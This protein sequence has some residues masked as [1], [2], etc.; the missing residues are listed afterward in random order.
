MVVVP[1]ELTALATE[2]STALLALPAYA[3]MPPRFAQD[4]PAVVTLSDFALRE[5]QQQAVD[6]APRIR[7]SWLWRDISIEDYRSRLA[8][9]LA[10]ATNERQVM[11]QL[12]IFR[13]SE[14]LR[15]VW[16]DL[17][18]AT[19]LAGILHDLS[20]LAD[21]CVQQALEW[22]WPRLCTQMGTP[23][24]VESGTPQ[25]LVVLALGKLG[26][27]ELNL[28][29]DIDLIFAYP[30]E[31]HTQGNDYAFSNH[32]FF[33]RLGQTLIRMLDEA[34][35]DGFVFRVDMRLRPFGEG[36]PL[37]GS[38]ASM[39]AYYQ[40]QG[41]EWE[42]YALIKAR[43]CAGD[44]AAGAQL[45]KAL[46]PFIFRRYIDFG[47]FESLR[48][49]K[50]MIA[51]EVQRKGNHDD[52][53]IGD[54]GIREVEFIAQTFQLIR[55]G[56][57]PALRDSH[58]LSLLPRLAERRLLPDEVVQTLLN[59]YVFLREAEH[60]IQALDERHSQ[61]LPTSDYDRLRLA[62]AMG[63]RNWPAFLSALDAWR[64][65]VAQ[66][67][68]DVITSEAHDDAPWQAFLPV[69]QGNC[70]DPAE[71]QA[72]LTR[73]GFAAP[74]VV[75][76]WLNTL[77]HSRAVAGLPALSRTRLDALM[78]RLLQSA[79]TTA[80]P[81]QTLE[82][83]LPLVEA[84]L[85]RTAYIM[86]LVE[87]RGALQRLVELAAASPWIAEELA[88]YPRLLD[89]LLDAQTL[90]AP[91]EPESLRD[92]L[93][94]QMQRLHHA[95]TAEETD[96][97]IEQQLDELRYFR[98]AHVLRV[99]ASDIT[100]CLPLMEVSDY[101]SGI[102][103]ALL[104]EVL[105]L[106]WQELVQKYGLPVRA[107]GRPCEPGF[108]ILGY[109]KLGGIELGYGSDLDLV[110]LHDGDE[111]RSTLATGEQR[112]LETGVFFARLVQRI[113]H[114]M[115]V[116]TRAGTL[117]EVDTRLRP[118]GASGLLVSSMPAFTEYQQHSA[119]TWEHQAL[120]RARV[121]TGCPQLAERFNQLRS[122]IL[123]RPRELAVLRQDVITMRD[124]MRLHLGSLAHATAAQTAPESPSTFDLK[125]DAGGIVDI[126]FMVQYAVLAWGH[127]HPSL[128][129]WTDNVRLIDALAD[130]RLLPETAAEVL[131][132]GY[133]R[134]RA[135]SHRQALA[136]AGNRVDGQ[137]FAALRADIIAI[138]N[139]LLVNAPDVSED[140]S[141]A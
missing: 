128:T 122:A 11:Q 119:W 104:S 75:S 10:E 44:R 102:A 4:L 80:R 2:R 118:S 105:A 38:F 111:Q 94:R 134:L 46:R 136:K 25:Q 133:L 13:R 110:F 34:T 107:D 103:E 78:P 92:E 45:L 43:V 85:R 81:D 139:S 98:K 68:A 53:K 62:A 17:M 130:A 125:H 124:K 72:L 77:R 51:R 3:N 96:A 15:I 66:H 63:Y 14:M 35:D 28:S 58:M 48:D 61:R 95:V 42:R 41:R 64:A 88:C 69:W 16:R 99:A 27:R 100:G 73:R 1:A 65:Q 54:G 47:V 101:L 74:A 30:E 79:S 39:E 93:R 8:A 91:P 76:Q 70:E 138:W 114:L 129:C 56:M 6:I 9:Q 132:E 117:Y 86:L 89:E 24:G 33:C 29:S 137:E 19:D 116:R 115:T 123:A 31:G 7:A 126:E 112:A 57:E 52:I 120:V 135:R 82:R 97:D 71:E 5:L 50:Q 26:G 108:V 140:M 20:M 113:L 106:A 131:R 141:N 21:V 37:V 49:M 60:R 127:N 121:V 90:Y 83:L 12:R 18:R 67:F 23:I 36:S 87:S 40:S 32:E 22:A 109:G 59:A 55:G 84:V